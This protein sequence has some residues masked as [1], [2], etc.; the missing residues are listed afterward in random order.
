MKRKKDKNKG[1]SIRVISQHKG[2]KRNPK[3]SKADGK[4]TIF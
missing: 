3:K 1:G 4:R 2:G